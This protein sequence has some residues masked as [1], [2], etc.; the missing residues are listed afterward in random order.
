MRDDPGAPPAGGD[1]RTASAPPVDSAPEHED[2][3]FHLYRGTEL[4]QDNRVMEAKEELEQALTLQP[5]DA[6]GQDLLAVVYFRIGL[7]PRAIQI[8]EGLMRTSPKDPALLLN[9]SLCYLKTGLTQKART[10][11][12]GL[13]AIQPQHR[14]AWGYL[15]LALERL[16]ELEG[17]VAAFEKGGHGSMAKRAA[18]KSVASPEAPTA[19]SSQPDRALDP[20]GALAEAFSELDAGELSFALAEPITGDYGG[21]QWAAIELGR[22]GSSPPSTGAMPRLA[23]AAI[24]RPATT[25]VVGLTPVPAPP[26]RP[27]AA[28]APAVPPV[29]APPPPQSASTLATGPGS[30]PYGPAS[31]APPSLAALS[32]TVA[33]AF[34]STPSVVHG[35]AGLLLVRTSAGRG[36]HDERAFAARMDAVRSMS[37]GL[38]TVVLERMQRG[39]STGEAFGGVGRPMSRVRGNGELSLGPRRA[40]GL[41]PFTIADE[42]CFLREDVLLGFE[43]TLAYENGKLAN[44]DGDTT[45]F[46]QLRGSGAVVLELMGALSSIALSSSRSVHVR[47]ELIV[48]WTGRLVPRAIPVSEAPSGQRGLVA[49]AGEGTVLLA[50]S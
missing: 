44:E 16:G 10:L 29:A 35:P 30:A 1:S 8:Y 43:L 36:D 48:G 19:V 25:M 49:F 27:G 39:A 7:Y 32:T 17:A 40:H 12:E 13:V 2:F 46:V 4:L 37:A 42:S 26:S 41:V 24:A 38:S 50:A 23:H 6:K 14:R 18:A 5:R 33:L 3:L 22:P 15:G 9:L 45:A 28:A 31:G 47:R 21:Q 20:R 34:P 11:L